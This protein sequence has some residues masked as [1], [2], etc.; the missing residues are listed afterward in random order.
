MER[1]YQKKKGGP[2]RKYD[3]NDIDPKT[4]RMRNISLEELVEDIGLENLEENE[5]DEILQNMPELQNNEQFKRS[6]KLQQET[7][8]KLRELY[9]DDEPYDAEVE[10]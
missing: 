10:D 9:G 4:G 2:K 7:N 6:I 5:L 1:E 3:P 8:D